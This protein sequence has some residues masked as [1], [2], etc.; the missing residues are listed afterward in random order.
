MSSKRIIR[1]SAVIKQEISTLIS[2][3][4]ELEGRLVTVADVE[5]TPDLRKAFIYVSLIETDP[6]II[7]ETVARLNANRKEWQAEL[8]RRLKLKFTPH[9]LFRYNNFLQRGD[10]VMEIL[11]EIKEE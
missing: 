10:R 4:K 8:N 2:R 1:V 6:E 11:Q 7:E 5:M 9:L 3:S